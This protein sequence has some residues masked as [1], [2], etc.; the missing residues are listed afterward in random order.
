MLLRLCVDCHKSI[1]ICNIVTIHFKDGKK[2]QGTGPVG[3]VSF[4][5][6][7]KFLYI[8]TK[9]FKLYTY[10]NKYENL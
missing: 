9:N 2:W 1:S 5:V 10:S 6:N 7:S 8:F 3:W 4:K